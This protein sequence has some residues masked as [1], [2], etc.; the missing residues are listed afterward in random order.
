MSMVSLP[1]ITECERTLSR[2][3]CLVRIARAGIF[4]LF[5]LLGAPVLLGQVFGIPLPTVLTLILSTLVLQA[6]AAFVGLGFGIHPAVLLALLTSVAV[7]VML[8]VLEIL[9]LLAEQSARVQGMVQRINARVAGIAYLQRYGAL[10]LV[11]IMWIPGIALYGTPVVA[12]LFQYQRT[13]SL[14]CMVA[15]WVIAVG[16]VMATALGL[17]RLAF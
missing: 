4:V 16:V 7:A 2:R 5:F 1:V 12:W 6:A 9:D 3:T 15:G 14:L 8:G 13:T 10:M 11:P 17:I